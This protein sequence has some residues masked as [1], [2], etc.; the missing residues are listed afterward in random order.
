MLLWEYGIALDARMKFLFRFQPKLPA[1]EGEC[2]VDVDQGDFV[3]ALHGPLHVESY[4]ARHLP[5][6]GLQL[7]NTIP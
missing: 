7:D 4:R 2:G 5:R 6:S 3:V 1:V